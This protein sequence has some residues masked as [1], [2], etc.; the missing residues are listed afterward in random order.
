MAGGKETPRQKMIGMMYLVLT[1]LLALQVSNA[2]LEKFIFID[3]ILQE[4]KEEDSHHNER[5]ISAIGTE[6]EKKGN[7]PADLKVLDKAEQVR[8]RTEE[9]IVYM[10]DMREKMVEITGGRDGNQ[11]I[12]G[13]KDYDKVGTYM[14]YQGKGKELRDKLNG[15][16][17][18]LRETTGDTESF[19]DLAKDAK[20]IP[21]AARDPNH[22]DKKFTEYYFE[23]TPTAAGM[24]T[25]SFISNQVLAYEAIALEDLAEMVGA[26]DVSFDQIFPIVLPKSNI[27]AAGAKFEGDLF[28]TAS[29]SAIDPEMAFNLNPAAKPADE[30][31]KDVEVVD[32]K[33]KIEFRASPAGS[34]NKDGLAEKKFSTFIT[35]NDST[36]EY[37]HTYFVAEPVITVQSAAVSALYFNCGN[38]LNIQVPALGTE[39][40]PTFSASGGSAIGGAQKGLVTIVPTDPKGV[41]IS[42]SSG[43]NRIGSR[44]FKVRGIPKPTIE[45]SDRGKKINMKQGVSAKQ[46]RSI[47]IRAIPDESFKSFLPKDARYRV[48]EWEI[49]LARGRSAVKTEKVRKQDLSLSSYVTQA[50]PGD[51]IVIEVKQV[52]RRNFQ[53]KNER[54]AGMSGQVFTIPLN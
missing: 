16:A 49:I 17:A 28:I 14:M 40:N 6:I 30:A 46:L 26:K 21:I 20:D 15:F 8:Q 39:Y 32:G 45:V 12:V 47:S 36:Y 53:D 22:R 33:G 25:M 54:V 5:L 34:Y 27:V 3:E 51:R 11:H 24:A 10:S 44:T 29:S 19:P 4:K 2:V 43:G 23:N 31:N 42:V 7:R 18:F 38:E 37:V 41:T 9:L 48:T 1:A 52:V 35:M 13:A 50:R